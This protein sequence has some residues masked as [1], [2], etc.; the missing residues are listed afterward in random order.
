MGNKQAHK[1]SNLKPIP[2][3][4][5]QVLEVP[6][7]ETT[8]FHPRSPYGVAK[9]YAFWIFVNYRCGMYEGGVGCVGG[10]LID[11]AMNLCPSHVPTRA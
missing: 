9:V 7:S 1:N 2:H 6:Q 3:P 10:S 11:H 4:R 8:P 5:T